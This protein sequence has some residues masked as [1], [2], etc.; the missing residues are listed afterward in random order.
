[1]TG[2]ENVVIPGTLETYV[3]AMA[4]SLI[5]AQSLQ[6][7]IAGWTDEQKETYRALYEAYAAKA[8]NYVEYTSVLGS[9]DYD[10]SREFALRRFADEIYKSVLGESM[11]GVSNWDAESAAAGRFGKMSFGYY[12]TL[13][14]GDYELAA[15]RMMEDRAVSASDYVSE[16]FAGENA[17]HVV[18]ADITR[19][20]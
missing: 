12:V 5:Y 16:D 15:E 2:S 19:F 8:K 3:E 9:E 10:A 17:R 14:G 11:S 6:L 4:Y 7:D 1:M 18:R 20:R 13:A